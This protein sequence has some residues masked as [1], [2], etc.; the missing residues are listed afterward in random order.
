MFSKHTRISRKIYTKLPSPKRVMHS[1][2]VSMRIFLLPKEYGGP[3]FMVTM[4]KKDA[5]TAVVRNRMRRRY[6]H[7][8]GRM[9]HKK[10]SGIGIQL[11]V[12]K[13]AVSVSAREA[14]EDLD[15]LTRSLMP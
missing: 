6:T 7:L 13:A 15:I 3:L 12:K 9:R 5:R 2:L 14:R 10:L 4:G 11:I 8:L 1:P